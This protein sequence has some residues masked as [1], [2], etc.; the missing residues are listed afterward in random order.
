MYRDGDWLGDWGHTREWVV[1]PVNQ[2][3]NECSSRTI[4]QNIRHARELF[5]HTRRRRWHLNV[6]SLC[7]WQEEG[8]IVEWGVRDKPPLH[9]GT[10]VQ[11]P[12]IQSLN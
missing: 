2:H 9:S 1:C 12:I 5:G 8:G 7:N 4:L 11:R 10:T 6:L 3:S